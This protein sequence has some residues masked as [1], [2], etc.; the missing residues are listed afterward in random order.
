MKLNG[1]EFGQETRI[2]IVWRYLSRRCQM[3]RMETVHEN[4]KLK[5]KEAMNW[6]SAALIRA[7]LVD[8][9]RQLRGLAFRTVTGMKGDQE[10]LADLVDHAS[11]EEYRRIELA[12]RGRER[13]T[14]ADIE[15]TIVR[16]DSGLFG[17]CEAC[18]GSI[19]AGRLM[20]KPTTIHCVK[21]QEKDE[22]DLRDKQG[23]PELF[24]AA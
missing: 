17:I 3:R 2:A 22:K 7:E 11:I 20:A 10:N 6:A 19:S 21:C 4:R 9:L 23:H 14:I 13:E 5:L 16:I 24:R 1:K 15:N 18:G 12:I 8:R